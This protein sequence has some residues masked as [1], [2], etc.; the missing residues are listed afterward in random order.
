[1]KAMVFT[2]TTVSGLLAACSTTGQVAPAPQGEQP[3]RVCRP[4]AA[5]KL[6]GYAAP[7]DAQ[8]KLRTGAELIRRIAPGDAVTHD[9]RD[10]RITLAI[11]PSGKVVQANCG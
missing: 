3:A 8:I 10:N 5:A 11:D 2:L 9:F 4:E 7:D 1:M 6:V